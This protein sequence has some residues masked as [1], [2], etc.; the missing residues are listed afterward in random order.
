MVNND[1]FFKA[2][3]KWIEELKKMEELKQRA[4]QQALAKYGLKYVAEHY[5]PEKLEDR[6]TWLP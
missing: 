2:H 5:L 3:P 6:S 1:P 4:E